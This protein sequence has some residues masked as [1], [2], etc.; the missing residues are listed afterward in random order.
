MPNSP[1]LNAKA[2]RQHQPVSAIV[3]ALAQG[4]VLSLVMVQA[5][6]QDLRAS[7]AYIPTLAESPTEGPFI[8]LVNA[9]D[10]VYSAGTISIEVFPFARSIQNV[11][12]D[13][14]D[15]HLPM[16]RSPHYSDQGRPFRLMN[17]PMGQ[18]C[19]VLYSHVD[20]RL[21]PQQLYRVKNAQIYPYH[22][23]VVR[24]SAQFI[25]LPVEEVTRIEQGLQQVALR[26]IDGFL[27]AQ[28]EADHVLRQLQLN[29][30][31]R[32]LFEC[33]DDVIILP[34]GDRGRRTEAILQ[35]ALETLEAQ[36]RLSELHRRVHQPYQDWQIYD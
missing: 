4:L 23:S 13:M 12:S 24:G 20:M 16:L 19:L 27:G 25:D 32:T 31:H 14:A 28:E 18:V 9:I 8:E 26:R 33:Y 21:R 1:T 35:Q 7:V 29:T 36:G 22:L 17:K 5:W 10:E 30:I 6:A 2:P 3:S 34:R 15:F 11:T